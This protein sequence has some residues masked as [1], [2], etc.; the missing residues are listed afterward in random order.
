MFVSSRS[1]LEGFVED[2][3]SRNHLIEY[4]GL[5]GCLLVCSCVLELDIRDV[6]AHETIEKP[7]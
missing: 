1:V 4:N 5:S 6:E 2:I 3:N 7:S